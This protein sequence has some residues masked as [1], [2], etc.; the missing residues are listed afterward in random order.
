MPAAR[1]PLLPDI[2]TARCTGCGWCVG[3]CPFHLLT[4][5]P[6]GWRKVSVLRDADRCT[7]C[8]KCEVKCPFN[9]ITM[10]DGLPPGPP[11]VEDQSAVMLASFTMRE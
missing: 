7:G 1:R 11:S 6:Q 4:L 3:A 10:R 8:R 2:D 9:V 5:D